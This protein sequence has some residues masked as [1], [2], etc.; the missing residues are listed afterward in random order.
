[1][2]VLAAGILLVFSSM[3]MTVGA[4]EIHGSVEQQ[5]LRAARP[6]SN[7]LLTL[8]SSTNV[9]S[10]RVYSDQ[11]G[12]FWFHDVPRGEYVLEIWRNGVPDAAGARTREACRI[13]VTGTDIALPRPLLLHSSSLRTSPELRDCSD[14]LEHL[15]TSG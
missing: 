15:Y 13:E 7:L 3:S 5:S 6:A 1:M 2:N 14:G 10:A 12:E 4:A 8:R 11:A 9:R